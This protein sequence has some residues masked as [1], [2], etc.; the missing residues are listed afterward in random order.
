LGIEPE[1][2]ETEH[3]SQIYL[4]VK[5]G[6]GMGLLIDHLKKSVGFSGETDDVFIA[7]KR[8]I[9][10]LAQGQKSVKNA[11]EQLQNQ[12]AELV[13]EDLRQAQNSLAEI[14]GAFSSDDLLGR[15]FSSFCI[16]K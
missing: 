5:K 8:H 3:G 1:I 16:G 10:A 15:I 13:A 11:L 4:S 12:A 2:T 6:L 7:R 9:D 14:T